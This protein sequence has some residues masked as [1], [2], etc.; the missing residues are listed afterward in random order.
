MVKKRTK[1]NT[2]I[3]FEEKGERFMICRSCES[4]YVTVGEQTVAVTCS[5]CVLMSKLRKFPGTI[6]KDWKKP[7][8]GRPSGWHFMNEWVEKDGNV[9][10]KG[11]EQPN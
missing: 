1:K 5:K 4:E 3:T 2:W 10:H 8:T 6:P 11:K 9:C 7:L